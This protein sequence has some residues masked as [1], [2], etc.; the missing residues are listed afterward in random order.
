MSKQDELRQKISH[1][2]VKALRAGIPPWRKPWSDLENS[3]FPTNILTRRKYSGINPLICQMVA[4]R[5]GFQ[6]K[7]WGTFNQFSGIGAKIKKRPADV[8]PGQ[9]GTRLI[10]AR[11]IVKNSVTAQ[12]D[13]QQSKFFVL[14]EFT[15]FNLDQVEGESLDHLRARPR[16]QSSFIDYEPA[17]RV[18]AATHADI[19]YGGNRAFYSRTD[20]YIQMPIKESFESQKEWYATHLHEL[21]HWSEKRLSWESSYAMNELVAEIG[22]CYLASEIGVPQS[23]DLSNHNAYLGHWLTELEN[24]PKAIFKAATQASKAADFILAFS[25]PP[26]DEAEDEGATATTQ[27]VGGAA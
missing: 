19:R 8:P 14:R 22:A 26:Q 7:F 16:N 6:S 9:W 21:C 12:G 13:E 17:E 18:I 15:V 5:Q 24:D 23:D 1:Q 20:D 25:R 3:G 10:F 2:M 11:P 4:Q 27:E